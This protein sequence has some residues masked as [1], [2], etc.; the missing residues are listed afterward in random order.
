MIPKN[1]KLAGIITKRDI[2]N[3]KNADD[4]VEKY[5]CKRENLKVIVVDK[6]P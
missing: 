6:D 1:L 2:K 3:M 4:L 5:M